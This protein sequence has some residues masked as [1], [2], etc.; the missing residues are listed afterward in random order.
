MFGLKITNVFKVDKSGKP[1][2]AR[3]LKIQ[4]F[5]REIEPPKSAR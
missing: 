2:Q 4:S 1:R 5:T 3:P